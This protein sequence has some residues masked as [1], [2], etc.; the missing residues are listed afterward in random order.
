M[1]TTSERPQK[2]SEMI[3][4][5]TVIRSLI[6]QS[7]K[8]TFFPTYVFSGKHGCGKTTSARILAKAILCRDKERGEPCGKCAFC[9]AIAEGAELDVTEIDGASNNGVDKVRELIEKVQFR[10]VHANKKVYIIDEVHMLSTGAFNALLKTLEEPPEWAVFI[11]ATTEPEKIPNTVRSRAACYSFTSIKDSDLAARL[12]SI[13]KKCGRKITYGALKTIVKHSEGSVRD[14]IRDLETCFE[15]VYE[16]EEITLDHVV[17]TLGIDSSEQ[18]MRLINALF[19]E[20]IPDILET[21]NRWQIEGKQPGYV[22][23][24]AIEALTDIVL[25]ITAKRA[26]N[27]PLALVETYAANISADHAFFILKDLIRIREMCRREANFSVIAAELILTA[28]EKDETAELIKR[29]E[30]LEGKKSAD[31]SEEFLARNACI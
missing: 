6:N 27:N 12:D 31:S 29:I 11:L 18:S 13:A 20:R 7:K 15:A 4:Q 19:N 16:D 30:R 10:P 23:G 2:F 24:Q 8:D 14:A 21:V 17:Q 26:I 3:G 25:F 9:K 22:L 5:E 28:R 1:L